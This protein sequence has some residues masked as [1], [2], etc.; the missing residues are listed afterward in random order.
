MGS[1]ATRAL[2]RCLLVNNHGLA[3]HKPRLCV[4]FITLHARMP[5]LQWE[6]RSFVVIKRRGGKTEAIVTIRTMRLVFFFELLVVGVSMAVFAYCGRAMEFYLIFAKRSFMALPALH[7]PVCSRQ[8]KLCL[9]VIKTS[10]VRPR[11]DVVACFA[12]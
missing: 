4:T 8:G 9:G 7:H 12:T 6:M 2:R 5:T 11:P 3:I 10:H 1:M